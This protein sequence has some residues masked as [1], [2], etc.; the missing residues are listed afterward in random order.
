M[1]SR[2][3]RQ[4]Q[5]F[6]PAQPA[7]DME[8]WKK[9]NT[10]QIALNKQAHTPASVCARKQRGRVREPRWLSSGSFPAEETLPPRGSVAAFATFSPPTVTGDAFHA[11]AGVGSRYAASPARVAQL[12]EVPPPAPTTAPPGGRAPRSVKIRRHVRSLS[13]RLN[14]TLRPRRGMTSARTRSGEQAGSPACFKNRSEGEGNI[15]AKV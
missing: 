1:T 10:H 8:Q 2:P 6:C 7:G 5:P 14:T 4:S 12:L 3:V 15:I 9:H 13:A 11:H